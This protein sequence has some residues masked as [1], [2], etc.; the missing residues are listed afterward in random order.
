MRPALELTSV[1][2]W[3]VTVTIPDAD[4]SGRR[5]TVVAFGPGT[6][7]VVS[8]WSD[9]IASRHGL[10]AVRVH[11]VNDDDAAR[12]AVDQDLDGA[13]VGWRLMMA[14][15]ADA[16]LRLRAHALAAGVSDDEI[17]VASTD[18]TTRDLRCVHCD[19]VTATSAAL[20]EVV[21]CRGCGRNLLVYYHVSRRLGAHL[22]FMIDAEEPAQAAAS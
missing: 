6:T 20:E 16:C 3:A 18:V 1:P 12:A 13:V 7:D 9:Q 17:T 19:A 14:G 10:A 11:R 2:H 22:G 21:G 8:R 4:L 15:P 5:W